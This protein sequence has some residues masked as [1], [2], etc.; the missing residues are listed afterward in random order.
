MEPLQS[1]PL[2]LRLTQPAMLAGVSLNYWGC[3]LAVVLAAFILLKSLA[4]LLLLLPL[5]G[6]GVVLCKIDAHIFSILFKQIELY[7]ARNNRI[8]GCQCYEPY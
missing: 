5:Y 7:D 8:W 6:L 4:M 3:C 1:A 2:C